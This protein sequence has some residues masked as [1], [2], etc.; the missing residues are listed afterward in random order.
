MRSDNLHADYSVRCLVRNNLEKPRDLT[1]YMSLA[2]GPELKVACFNLDSL[3]YG[4]LLF[5]PD[6]RNL[7]RCEDG[8]GDNAVVHLFICA[9]NIPCS[10]YP[11]T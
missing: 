4:L 8:R 3:L 10:D 2:Y 1:Y 7:R 11:F 6:R 9:C 5:E